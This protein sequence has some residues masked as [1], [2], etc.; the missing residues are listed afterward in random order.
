M[1]RFPI[2]VLLML[3]S[4]PVVGN[5]QSIDR[6]GWNAKFQSTYIWQ[7]KQPFGA[8]YSGPN[9][10]S[11][12]KERSYSFTATAALGFRLWPG[13][14]FY[15]N[16]EGVQ[17]VPLSRLTGLGG[18]TN[19]EIARTSGPNLTVYRARLFMRQSW[20]FGGGTENIELDINQL[21]GLADKRRLVLTVGNLSVIDIF[22][23]N[24]FSHDPRTQFM[25]W[26]IMTHGAYDFAADARGYS[27]G[28]ALEYFHDDWAVRAGRFA[29]PKEPNQLKLDYGIA[30]H[31]GDQIEVERGY[32]LSGQ[33]GKI[34]VLVFRNYA[35]MSRFNDA[36][37]VGIATAT[38]PDINIVRLSNQVKRGI[39]INIEQAFSNDAGLFA[40]ALWADGKTETYA[41]T[42]IDQSI[43]GGVVVRGTRW[44]RGKDSLGVA[45]AS[46]GLSTEHR[47]Y[48]AA[49][50]IGYF[51]GDGKLNYRR[52][53]IVETYYS[54]SMG[55]YAWLSLGWQHIKHPAYN[56]DR[57]AVTVTTLRL[58]TEF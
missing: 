51:I 32:T 28:A 12:Q 18:F 8:Q 22:D 52:E 16:P 40:R 14:E 53:S 55:K 6:E 41:F 49:G 20:G 42:E 24:A 10:L 50:G 4:M 5:A 39:G 56:A 34:R 33:P 21:A 46:N 45:Y 54:L 13:S 15:V 37:A 26:S 30:K 23:D 44:G 57:G 29:Q 47:N 58:H 48:L 31:F 38:T 3:V 17:G 1:S 2:L 25:N 9:S 7:G 27:V 19:G 36:L 43:S 11:P 35:K